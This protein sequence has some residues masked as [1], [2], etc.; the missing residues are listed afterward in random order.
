[1][2][3]LP[4]AAGC[5]ADFCCGSSTSFLHRLLCLSMVKKQRRQLR[6][7][8]QPNYAMVQ[9]EYTVRGCRASWCFMTSRQT[10]RRCK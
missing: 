7:E 4:S 1:M 10:A 9:A 8:R 2:G 3:L 6:E 5:Q